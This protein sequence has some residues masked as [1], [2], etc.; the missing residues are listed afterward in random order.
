MC[1]RMKEVPGLKEYHLHADIEMLA[2]K[3][4]RKWKRPS[5][6]LDFEVDLLSM[7]DRVVSF[8]SKTF[9]SNLW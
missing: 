4:G 5:I 1:A 8:S 7:A 9:L 2:S 6:S 3:D